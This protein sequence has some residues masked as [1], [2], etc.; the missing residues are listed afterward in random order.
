MRREVRWV[1]VARH[2]ESHW[3]LSKSD[4]SR[5]NQVV[6]EDETRG[7]VSESSKTR[8][9]PLVIIKVRSF[10][11]ESG[12]E[13]LSN[14]DLVVLSVFLTLGVG[15]NQLAVNPA[16]TQTAE[17]HHSTWTRVPP[18]IYE[19]LTCNADNI[20]IWRRFQ[21]C[22]SMLAQ[23]MLWPSTCL[24]LI[25]HGSAKTAKGGIIQ[26]TPHNSLQTPFLWH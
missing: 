19:L 11:W 21:L 3:S 7:P 10:L 5:G 25:S 12:S 20:A 23:Y 15:D 2:D 22:N 9:I 24:S 4:H 13:S 18:F 6:E 16:V 1:K 8:W 14:S 26:T 17:V